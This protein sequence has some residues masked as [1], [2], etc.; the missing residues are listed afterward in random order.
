[1]HEKKRATDK[2]AKMFGINISRTP[3]SIQTCITIKENVMMKE[4]AAL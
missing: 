1:M 3:E 4:A 2:L